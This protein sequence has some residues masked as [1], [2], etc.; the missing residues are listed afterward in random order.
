MGAAQAGVPSAGG[1]LRE[2]P[3]PQV[4]LTFSSGLFQGKTHLMKCCTDN[5]CFCGR[6]ELQLGALFAECCAQVVGA[7][8]VA[9]GQAVFGQSWLAEPGLEAQGSCGKGELRFV[10]PPSPFAG[11]CVKGGKAF[12]ANMALCI[13][14]KVKLCRPNCVLDRNRPPGT[15][16]RSA[17]DCTHYGMFS[18]GCCWHCSAMLTG[19]RLRPL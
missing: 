3:Q 19:V 7:L 2:G 8:A 4:R 11:R 15:L 18:P 5:W 16:C 14:G 9:A 10:V 1:N 6:G 17:V 13:S 12:S